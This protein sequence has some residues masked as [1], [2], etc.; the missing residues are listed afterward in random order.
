M[1][2][3]MINENKAVKIFENQEF[4]K[5]RVIIDPDYFVEEM[6]LKH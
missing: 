5:I 2:V 6:L 4:G 1:A 3:K